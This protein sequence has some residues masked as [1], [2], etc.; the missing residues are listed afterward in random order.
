[1][2]IK[3]NAVSAMAMSETQWNAKHYKLKDNAVGVDAW[4]NRYCS[5]IATYYEPSE[6][7]PMNTDEIEKYKQAVK[8]QRQDRAVRMAHEKAVRQA[9]EDYMLQKRNEY[10][11]A[12]Q[13]L[14][15]GYVVKSG[16]SATIGSELQNKDENYFSDN[17][18]YYNVKDVE[19]N[20]T[21]ASELL[22]NFDCNN[23]DGCIWW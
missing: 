23:Y 13:W 4:T 19:R 12:C 18:Y 14:A 16:S 9:H 15:K 6:V 10:N 5:H 17:Y 7:E 20:D 22:N 3:E 2:H 1:M 11:T 8:Q 21:L